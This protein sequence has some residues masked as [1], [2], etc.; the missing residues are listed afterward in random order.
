MVRIIVGGKKRRYTGHMAHKFLERENESLRRLTLPQGAKAYALLRKQVTEAGI[1][2][3]DYVYYAWMSVVSLGGFILSGY[4]FW[5][6]TNPV[7]VVVWGLLFA[8][9][10]VQVGGIVHDAGHRA[11]FNSPKW[12]DVVG[13]ICGGLITFA[14]T[15]WRIKHNAHHAH[16]NE[17]GSD[18]D[19]EIPFSFTDDRFAGA[20]GFIGFVRKYQMWLY[21]P[22]G[23]LAT[24]S[25]RFKALKF[26]K[27]QFTPWMIPELVVFFIGVVA[28]YILPFF[29]FPLW[30]AILFLLVGNPVVGFYILNVFA[31]NHKGMPQLGRGVKLSFIE[32]QII[33]ARNIYGHWLTDYV[34]LGL[35]YQIEHHLFPYCPRNKLKL[36]TPYVLAICKKYK[37][38]YTQMSVIESNRFI[39]SELRA[40]SKAA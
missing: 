27:N 1:L 16:V 26:Y 14:Y 6:Q 3:R 25:M 35:N 7:I 15:N 13:Y 30:K 39:L 31:P 8:F 24:L 28:W 2:D 12:N 29:F 17:E 33:T 34:Y 18:P 23:S 9:F 22:L 19:I 11:I 4:E 20:K 36:V 5:V 10:L 21:Y 38:A 37:L 32:Q 40:V